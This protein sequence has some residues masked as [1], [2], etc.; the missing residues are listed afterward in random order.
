MPTNVSNSGLFKLIKTMIIRGA[1]VFFPFAAMLY[2]LNLAMGIAHGWIGHIAQAFVQHVTPDWAEF[3]S[4]PI[5]SLVLVLGIFCAL[6]VVV[7]SH[8]GAAILRWLEERI[9]S[10]KGIGDIYGILRRVMTMVGEADGKSKFKRVVFVPFTAE[11]GLTIGF[12]TN[13]ITNLTNGKSYLLV[14]VPTPPNPISGLILAVPAEKV[15]DPGLTVEQAVELCVSLGM[16]A[17]SSM[18]L[19]PEHLAEETRLIGELQADQA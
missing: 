6:G 19:T 4:S 17:P 1:M 5:I 13:E 16:S 12:V 3:L 11:G 9:L 8:I 15:S 10:I 18:K 7:S 14:F 2:G